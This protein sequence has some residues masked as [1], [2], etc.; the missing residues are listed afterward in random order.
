[1]MSALPAAQSAFAAALTTADAPM[2]VGLVCW[3]GA[4]PERRFEVYRNNVRASLTSALATAFPAVERVVGAEFFAAMAQAYV[5]AHPPRS[6]VLLGYGADF[7]DFVAG[8]E[9]A[10]ALPYLADVARLETLRRRAYHAADTL[11]LALDALSAVPPEAMADLTFTA[12]PALGVLRSPFP[13]HT[14]WAM[15]AGE[16]PLR[17][18]EDWAPEDVLV[19]RPQMRVSVSRLPVGA[20]VFIEHLTAGRNLADALEAAEAMASGFD[21]VTALGLALTAG[22]FS[23]IHWEAPHD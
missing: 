4:P 8:F 23:A 11:P 12:H 20:A 5:Q 3:T 7:A 13:V 17:P 15:N 2:P 18:I 1:M 10:E 14:I 21:V 16:V 6:P 19:S 22:A 9:P